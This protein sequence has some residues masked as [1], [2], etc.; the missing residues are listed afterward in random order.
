M[1]V[2]DEMRTCDIWT[3]RECTHCKGLFTN[4]VGIFWGLYLSAY[5]QL[6]AC[7]L[8]LEIDDVICEQP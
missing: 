1:Q 3:Y 2:Q 6:L 4:D 8:V 7:P 5:P